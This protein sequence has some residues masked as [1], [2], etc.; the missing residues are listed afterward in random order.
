MHEKSTHVHHGEEEVDRLPD[1]DTRSPEVKIFSQIRLFYWWPVWVTGFIMA[2]LTH[3]QGVHVK[4]EGMDEYIHPSDNVGLIFLTVLFVAII[5]TSFSFRGFRSIGLIGVIVIAV[6]LVS[7][8]GWWNFLIERIEYLSV[9]MNTGFYL[10]FSSLLSVL[11]LYATLIHPRFTYYRVRPGQISKVHL[12]GEGET[13]YD[14]R[15]AV[16]EKF[17]E[18]IFRHWILGLGAGD[19]KIS[20]TGAR[21]EELLIKDVLLVDRKVSRIRKLMA[22]KPDDL[23]EV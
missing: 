16:L 6:L 14:T 15:G 23:M 9:H 19:I 7:L 1:P 20:T 11:W 8:F 4:G 10:V 17:R 22:V 5:F 13:N 18:D 12:V 2:A 3:F 21:A